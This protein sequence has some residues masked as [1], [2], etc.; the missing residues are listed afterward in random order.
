[1]RLDPLAEILRSDLAGARVCSEAELQAWIERILK[2][3]GVS[4]VREAILDVGRPDFMVGRVAVEVKIKGSRMD[5]IRQVQRYTTSPK[6]DEVLVVTTRLS[7][8]VPATLGGKRVHVIWLTLFG[9]V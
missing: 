1:M 7:H 2:A 9:V 5:L 6:V 8:T 4:H 3:H